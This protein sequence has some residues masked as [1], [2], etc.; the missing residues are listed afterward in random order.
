MRA[1]PIGQSRPGPE[2]HLAAGAV[3]EIDLAVLGLKAVPQRRLAAALAFQRGERELDVLAGAERVRG[4]IGTGAVVVAAVCS[5]E[6][7]RGRCS[8]FAD[9]STSNSEKTG[10]SPTF[11]SRKFCSRPNWRRSSICQ[12]SSDM[13]AGRWRREILR[14]LSLPLRFFGERRPSARWAARPRG[15]GDRSSEVMEAL[16]LEVFFVTCQ[17]MNEG[18]H[19]GVVGDAYSKSWNGCGSKKNAGKGVQRGE[20]CRP[21]GICR[22]CLACGT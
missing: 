11:L 1:H 8:G 5:R 6:C 22:G 18:L 15:S 10:W 2:A 20:V 19:H 4:E 17:R 14:S 7:G 3:L 16:C 21:S 12:S 13:S 9:W